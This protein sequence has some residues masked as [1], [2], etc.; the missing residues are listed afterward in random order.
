MKEVEQ[1][2]LRIELSNSARIGGMLFADNFVGVSE[3]LQIV[4]AYCCKWRL[5]ANV[6]KSAVMVFARDVVY[7]R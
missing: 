7:R 5:K 3:Q 6:S 2:E 1:A 4:H